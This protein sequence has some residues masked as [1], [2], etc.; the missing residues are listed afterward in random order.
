MVCGDIH[1]AS[2]YDMACKV[3][4]VGLQHRFCGLQWSTC[5]TPVTAPTRTELCTMYAN[6]VSGRNS[7]HQQLVRGVVMPRVMYSTERPLQHIHH[8]Y[9][10]TLQ[11]WRNSMTARGVGVVRL[12]VDD[13]LVAVGVI[14]APSR[15]Q[16]RRGVCA[17]RAE[18]VVNPL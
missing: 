15:A 2:R 6:V 13:N 3:H 10:G 16:Q 1:N 14:G 12:H 17:Q 11:T 18:L 4:H 5:A 8:N 7:P 9:D